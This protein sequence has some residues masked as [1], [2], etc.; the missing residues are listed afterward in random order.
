MRNIPEFQLTKR[1]SC[2]DGAP[3]EEFPAQQTGSPPNPL[4]SP[5]G[6]FGCFQR[7]LLLLSLFCA[8]T[9]FCRLRTTPPQPH[10]QAMGVNTG[11]TYAP[12][13]DSEKRPITAGGFVKT[14]P[15]GL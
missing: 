2:V 5:R 4:S 3:V 13:L 14:G 11:G 7:N 9:Q 6:E 12:V 10:P 15:G 1:E 8:L